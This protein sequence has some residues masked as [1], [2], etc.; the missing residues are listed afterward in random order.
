VKKSDFLM[1]PFNLGKKALKKLKKREKPSPAYKKH[2]LL[3]MPLG[4]ASTSATF[5]ISK[6]Q[7]YL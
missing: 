5:L 4:G 2:N 3:P 7:L 1:R 6:K